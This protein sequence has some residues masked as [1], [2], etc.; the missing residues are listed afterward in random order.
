MNTRRI[1]PLQ[2][3]PARPTAVEQAARP[4]LSAPPP[5]TLY[6]HFPWCVRKCPYCDFNSHTP[7]AGGVPE[8]AWVDAVIAAYIFL[9]GIFLGEVLEDV[10][11]VLSNEFSYYYKNYTLY[12]IR[13]FLLYTS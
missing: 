2:P 12:S 8:A 10:A 9:R 1:I 7:R 5:L 3:A 11:T 6:V 13:G 4:Q